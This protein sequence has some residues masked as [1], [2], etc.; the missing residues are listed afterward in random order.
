MVLPQQAITLVKHDLPLFRSGRLVLVAAFLE[1]Q[2]DS[3]TFPPT[4][5]EKLT[6]PD[7][8]FGLFLKMGATLAFLWS[9]R[10]S[11]IVTISHRLQEWPSYNT[12][13]FSTFG[14]N[15]SDSVSLESRDGMKNLPFLI[16]VPVTENALWR[17]DGLS[18][19]S[20]PAT[21]T[22][23]NLIDL[24]FIKGTSFV[25]WHKLPSF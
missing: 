1:A 24:C 14:C 23:M 2:E 11:P 12:G 22:V 20:L 19:M 4:G 7:C 21:V 17:S 15:S 13:P 18:V 9:L 16:F 10:T 6:S 25:S 5:W 3:M 8:L